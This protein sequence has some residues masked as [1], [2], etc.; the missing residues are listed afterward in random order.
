[1]DDL[2]VSVIVPVYNVERY[3]DR[4]VGS[5]VG[6]T[7]KNLEII[8]VDDGSPDQCPEMC[9]AWGQKDSRIKVI[10]KKNGGLGDARNAGLDVAT[11]NLIGFIDSDDWCEST[12]FERMV[13]T[14]REYRTSIVVCDVWVDWENGWP[15]ETK[16]MGGNSPVWNRLE[17]AEAFYGEDFPAWMCN[18]IFERSLWNGV[19][20][21]A[22]LYEDIPVMRGFLSSING[23]AF[24]H[25]AEYH[26]I[27]HQ[28]SIVNSEIKESHL[29]L[30]NEMVESY[31]CAELVSEKA[32]INARRE[33]VWEAYCLLY[34]MVVRKVMVEKQ[35]EM[36]E[37]IRQY[38]KGPDSM[39]S[40]GTFDKI[41]VK[42]I[43]TGE[44]FKYLIKAHNVLQ[45]LYF[46][47]KI[48]ELIGKKR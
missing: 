28:N 15:S 3:L 46:K 40:S 6:Q 5:I 16:C 39:R 48:K 7:Y 43:A 4:C 35:R 9:D 21:S 36:V 12:M 33:V 29:T 19:R 13:A 17:T 11:G 24:T 23:V 42:K 31:K 47:L 27:Q 37:I 44:R 8:L 22:Q 26:Y 41:I 34:K 45:N 30:L 25:S 38:W 14:Y 1:M 10:H 18:K 20:F 2:K 32:T